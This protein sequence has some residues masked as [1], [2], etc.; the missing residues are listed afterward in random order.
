MTT[1]EKEGGCGDDDGRGSELEEEACVELARAG[2]DDDTPWIRDRTQALSP[3]MG[4]D[5]GLSLVVLSSS[6]VCMGTLMAWSSTEEWL[7]VAWGHCDI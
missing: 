2:E 7:V 4:P 1:L 3:A 6:G 5:N